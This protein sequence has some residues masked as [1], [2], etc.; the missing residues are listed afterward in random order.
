MPELVDMWL[1]NTFSDS[2]CLPEAWIGARPCLTHLLATPVGR[3]SLKLLPD[4]VVDALVTATA[5]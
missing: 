4:D 3:Q 1:L 2:R 5:A